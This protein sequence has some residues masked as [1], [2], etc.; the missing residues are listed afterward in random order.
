MKIAWGGWVPLLGALICGVDSKTT[1]KGA[2]MKITQ[3][4]S[5]LSRTGRECCT[6]SGA[7]SP[8]EKLL[9]RSLLLLFLAGVFGFAAGCTLLRF[10]R[11]GEGK[12]AAQPRLV[13]EQAQLQRFADNFLAWGGQGLDKSAERL[14]TEAGREQVLRIK[15]LLG[16]SLLSIVSGPNPNANLLDLVCVTVLTRMSIEDYWMHTTNGAAFQPWLDVSRVL[17]TNVWDLAARFLEP[18]HVAEL[19]AAIKEGYARTPDPEVRTA[20]FAR[21]YTF[22]AMVSAAQGKEAPKGSVFSLVSL[23][24]T[25]GLDPAVREVTQSRLFA[26]RAMYTAQRMPFLLRLQGE[27]LAYDVADQPSTRLVLTNS[28]Q[29]SGSAERISRAAESLAQTVGQLPDRISA[30]RKEVLAALE[31]QQGPL[32]DLVAGVDRALVSGEKMSSS[33]TVTLT[34]AQGLVGQLRGGERRTNAPPFNILDYAK[35]A[36]EV[37]AMAQNLNTLVGSLNQSEPEIQR[38][39]RQADADLERAVDRAFRLGLVLIAV[40]LTGAVLAGLAYR[41]FAEKLWPRAAVGPRP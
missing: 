5:G 2:P 24:P 16:S 11:G 28:T 23:D 30:E 39:S 34:N 26:E 36:E 29:L 31:S 41:F 1:R 9:T 18:A 14:G 40:L 33:M 7:H 25:A 10:G 38:L 35:T 19:R 32:R 37:D 22:T 13:E 6:P 27:L 20:F 8:P 17:E 4:L 15:L 12:P 3:A 21:P